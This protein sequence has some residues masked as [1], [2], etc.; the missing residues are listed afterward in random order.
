MDNI[1]SWVYCK[2]CFWCCGQPWR[3]T[4]LKAMSVP[5]LH[6]VCVSI[7]LAWNTEQPWGQCRCYNTSTF[8][9][10]KILSFLRNTLVSFVKMVRLLPSLIVPPICPGLCSGISIT[11]KGPSLN[12]YSRQVRLQQDYFWIYKELTTGC[13]E[14]GSNSVELASKYKTGKDMVMFKCIHQSLLP[15]L[16]VVNIVRLSYIELDNN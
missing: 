16:W 5:F 8:G 15:K 10:E 9:W 14:S 2:P 3:S 4:N 13:F 11:C 1:V 12:L 6:I 7:K